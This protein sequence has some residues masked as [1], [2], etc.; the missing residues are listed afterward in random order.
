MECYTVNCVGDGTLLPLHISYTVMCVGDGALFLTV[1]WLG[2][3]T[4]GSTHSCPLGNPPTVMWLGD[5]PS[6]SLQ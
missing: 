5:G 1:I 3:G 6:K 4:L 2:D